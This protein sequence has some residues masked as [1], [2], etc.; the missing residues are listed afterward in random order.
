[1]GLL[2]IGTFSRASH[3]SV[4]TLRRYHEQ[5]LLRPAVVDP[6]TGYRGYAPAQLADAQLIR[7]LRELDLPLEDVRRILEARDPEV[8]R[9]ALVTHRDRAHGRLEETRRILGDLDDLLGDPAASLEAPISV[10]AQQAEHVAR[11]STTTTLAELP[12]FFAEAYGEL[13]ATLDV[14]GRR[15]TGSPGALFGG[16]EFD[17]DRLVVDAF[18]PVARP[19]PAVGRVRPHRLPAARLATVLHRGSYDDIGAAYRRL[20]A[21]VADEGL[22]PVGAL[23]ERYLTG[24]GQGVDAAALRTEVAWPIEHDHEET[25]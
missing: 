25:P 22:A 16:E 23:Q 3:L 17:P 2:A 20:A 10:R 18:V 11:V 5:G 4:R 6:A 24:P 12:A 14:Y 19:A 1:M 13:F 21:F 9:A 8:T 7:R 15:P